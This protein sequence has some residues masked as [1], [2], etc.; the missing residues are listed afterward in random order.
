[1]RK[2]RLGKEDENEYEELRKLREETK[3]IRMKDLK[4]RST[5]LACLNYC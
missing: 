5:N 2:L 4:I 3:K 1:M